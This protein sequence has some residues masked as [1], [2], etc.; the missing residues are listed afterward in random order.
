MGWAGIRATVAL[1]ARVRIE[2]LGEAQ[3]LES[4]DPEL[5]HG[6]VF[7][8]ERFERAKRHGRAVDVPALEGKAGGRGEE[9]DVL[10]TRKIGEES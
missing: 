7:E 10:G 2:E 1:D 9:V 5:L 3:L 6:V 4:L 8:I